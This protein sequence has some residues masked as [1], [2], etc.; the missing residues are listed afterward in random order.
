MELTIFLLQE[1]ILRISLETATKISMA[2]GIKRTVQAEARTLLAAF[3][4]GPSQVENGYVLCN[5]DSALQQM[6][7]PEQIHFSY[8]TTFELDRK[9]VV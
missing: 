9:S 4:V 3:G 1:F 2:P 6:N 5:G 7:P 8:I